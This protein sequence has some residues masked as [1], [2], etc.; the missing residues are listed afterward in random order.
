VPHAPRAKNGVGDIFDGFAFERL[1]EWT[2][3]I[4]TPGRAFDACAI[5]FR[6]A[7]ALGID[8]VREIAD[9]AF[10]LQRLPVDS[11]GDTEPAQEGLALT[12]RNL[13]NLAVIPV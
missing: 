9:V 4:C 3:A 7:L 11:E 5:N 6:A 8:N 2:R 12:R 10:R 1:P 13:F